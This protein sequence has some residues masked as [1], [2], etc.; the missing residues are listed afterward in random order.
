VELLATAQVDLNG[1]T[2]GTEVAGTPVVAGHCVTVQPGQLV[3]LARGLEPTLNGGLP[4]PLATFGMDLRNASGAVVVRSGDVILDGLVYGATEEGVALQVSADKVDIWR[5]D[6]PGSRCPATEAY[7]TAGNLGSPGRTNRVCPAG[8]AWDGGSGGELPVTC[9]DPV[10]RLR[11]PVRVAGAGA[12]A[13]TEYMAD[14]S[15]VTDTLGEWVELYALREVDLNGVTLSNEA[16]ARTTFEAT[17]C[18]A[19]KAGSFAVLAHS[20]EGS[21]NGGLPPV[22]GTFSFALGNGAGTRLLRLSRE[23]TVL[24]EV[25]WRSAA[26]PGVSMQLDALL[27][28][29]ARN[30]AP[31]AFCPSPEGVRYGVGDRGTPGAE[32]RR[33]GL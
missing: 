19:M 3:L 33:C 21:A 17:H 24:D 10:T 23:A 26:Q 6:D 25:T 20:T 22:L 4:T 14:P 13:L 32:N 15:A 31:G 5:N 28:D 1:V 7:G 29:P 8:G 18:L 30:D 9:E 2:V 12:L 16:G 27:K 11:R